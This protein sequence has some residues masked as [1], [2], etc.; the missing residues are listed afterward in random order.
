MCF[1]MSIL[2]L[3]MR[4]WNASRGSEEAGRRS[5]WLHHRGRDAPVAP[6]RFRDETAVSTV[7]GDRMMGQSVQS[8][9]NAKLPVATLKK[10][11]G[12]TWY[13]DV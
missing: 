5:Q 9:P 10:E 13:L 12:G 11:F 6:P 3:G 8:Y 4:L 7:E 1:L 2:T